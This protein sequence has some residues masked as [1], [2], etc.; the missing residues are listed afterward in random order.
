V[1]LIPSKNTSRPATPKATADSRCEALDWVM[2]HEAQ[3]PQSPLAK[4]NT[5]AAMPST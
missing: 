2:P 1:V 3:K 5:Q 4:W